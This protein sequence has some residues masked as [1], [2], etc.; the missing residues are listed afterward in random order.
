MDDVPKSAVT[1][2]IGTIL[3]AKKIVMVVSGANK[4][5]AVKAMIS[6]PVD[7]QMPA[8]AL[9]NHSDVTVFADKEAATLL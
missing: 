7:P 3:R 1:M 6:G 8:S 4:A 2:G 9:Q 5:K